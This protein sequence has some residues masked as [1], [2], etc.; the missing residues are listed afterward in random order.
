MIMAKKRNAA[1]AG[2]FMFI[3]LAMV[4]AV[5]IALGGGNRFTQN[6]NTFVISFNLSDDIGGLQIGDDVR[7]GGLKVGSVKNIQIETPPNSSENKNLAV[8]VYID[9]PTKYTVRSDAK[10]SIQKGL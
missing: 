3:S 7:L 4:V 10:I 6:F 9:L 2:I 5:V 8:D 1:R